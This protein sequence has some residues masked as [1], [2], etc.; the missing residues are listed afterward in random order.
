MLLSVRSVVVAPVQPV[1]LPT[2]RVPM[3]A[4]LVRSS[5][6]EARPDTYREVVVALVVVDL[7]MESKICAPVKVF[8]L[9]VLGIVVEALIYV[10]TLVSV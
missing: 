10:L 1:Q 9:Y 6:V 5:V 3:V 2:V 7:V 4:V 8:A